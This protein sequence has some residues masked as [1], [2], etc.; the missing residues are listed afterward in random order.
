MS[1]AQFIEHVL[2]D[3][4]LQTRLKT[5]LDTQPLSFKVWETA[6]TEFGFTF[7]EPELDTVFTEHPELMSRLYVL[8]EML[9]IT[10]YDD[11]EFEL[12][13]ADLHAIAGGGD[14]GVNM[15]S[16]NG[17]S[18]NISPNGRMIVGLNKL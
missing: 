11:E 2:T 7:T 8:A 17:R 13:E 15:V 6:A 1:A 18:Q 3:Q 9:G 14:P 4:S 16:N 10:L 5:L 12:S